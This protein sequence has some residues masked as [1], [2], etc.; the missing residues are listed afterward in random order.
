MLYEY[1]K[2]VLTIEI[3]TVISS[4]NDHCKLRSLGYTDSPRSLFI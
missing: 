2:D 4:R 1:Y 3:I